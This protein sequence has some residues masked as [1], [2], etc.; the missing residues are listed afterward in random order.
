M[1]DFLSMEIPVLLPK[2]S[3]KIILSENSRETLFLILFAI[4]VIISL[5]DMSEF[6]FSID[7]LYVFVI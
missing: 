2:I 1:S 3:I 6:R 4:F 7:I 5:L